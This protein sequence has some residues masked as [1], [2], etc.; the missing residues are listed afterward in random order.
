MQP[1][2]PSNSRSLSNYGV[3]VAVCETRSRV[4]TN[5]AAA[6]PLK[7]LICLQAVNQCKQKHSAVLLYTM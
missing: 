6:I 3:H 7:Q 4:S 2:G 5:T 1:C